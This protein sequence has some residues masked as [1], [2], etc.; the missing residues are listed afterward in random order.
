MK[1]TKQ[2][3]EDFQYIFIYLKVSNKKD[4]RDIKLTCVVDSGEFYNSF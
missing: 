1:F 3:I 4:G 2:G